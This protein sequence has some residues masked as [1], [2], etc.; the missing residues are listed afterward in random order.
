[1][2][3]QAKKTWDNILKYLQERINPQSFTTWFGSSRG[4]ELKDDVL[5]VEFPNGFF[6]DWI[7]EHYYSVLEEAVNHVNGEKLRL[8][9]KAV[10]QQGDR[11]IRK[12][13]RI[14][15]SHASTKLQ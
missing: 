12:K 8:A 15:L 3:E 2:T 5:L 9:F 1:M 7:E 10:K 11:P 4:V 6:I 13:K 14:I